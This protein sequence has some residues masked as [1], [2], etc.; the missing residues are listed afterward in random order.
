MLFLSP[1]WLATLGAVLYGLKLTSNRLNLPE[2]AQAAELLM[3]FGVAA[4]VFLV[5]ALAFR[6][7]PE[8]RQGEDDEDK[9]D[10]DADEDEAA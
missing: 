7:P 4:W 6:K 5:P 1:L 3:A 10:E 8:A 9:E 2:S